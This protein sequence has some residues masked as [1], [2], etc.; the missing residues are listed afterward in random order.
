MGSLH[1]TIALPL[2][3]APAAAQSLNLRQTEFGPPPSPS[4]GAA[5]GQVGV[6]NAL[7]TPDFGS[8]AAITPLVGLDGGSVPVVASVKGCDAYSCDW[9]GYGDDVANLFVGTVNGDCYA[10]P[11]STTLS[12]LQPGSYVLVAYG[13]PCWSTPNVQLSVS[14]SDLSYNVTS[15]NFGEY[16]GTFDTMTLSTHAFDVSA[17]VSVRLA[18]QYFAYLSAAQ[19][20][21]VEPPAAFCTSKQ[22]S[23]GCSAK[24]AAIGDAASL[25]DAAPFHVVATDVVN[26]VPGLLFYGFAEDV[27]PFMGGVHCVKPPTPRTWVQFSGGDGVPCGGTFDLDF[28]GW[29]SGDPVP[30]VYAG[31]RLH[32]QYWYRD[33]DDPFGAATSDAVS[34]HV[35]P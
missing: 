25:S 29:L 35:V 17:G 16:L 18:G 9:T 4:F 21:R 5:I 28:N 11:S 15:P 22:N 26:D 33:V 1:L 3:V 31:A 20:V 14:L 13:S 34:F 7:A 23:Q 32:A 12:G 27:K 10:D 2:L 6:W 8:G 19:L 30:K 24:I